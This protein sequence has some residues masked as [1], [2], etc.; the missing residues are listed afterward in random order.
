MITFGFETLGDREP[1]LFF[2]LDHY[3]PE[4]DIIRL[5]PEYRSEQEIALWVEWVVDEAKKAGERAKKE[6]RK[7][8]A[9][10][11]TSS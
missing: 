5:S 7:R 6:L 8:R 1:A 9:T 11:S 4:G 3:H 2:T 10:S